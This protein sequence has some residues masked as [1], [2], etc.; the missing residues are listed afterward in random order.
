M[1]SKI[2]NFV[3]LLVNMG[4]T[5][6]EKYFAFQK[7]SIELYLPLKVKVNIHFSEKRYHKRNFKKID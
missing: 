3:P 2:L 6:I 1:N 5:W 7:H 4:F